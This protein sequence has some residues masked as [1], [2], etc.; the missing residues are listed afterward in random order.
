MSRIL[1][2][3]DD[4]AV[5]SLIKTLLERK[6][7][8]V[9]EAPDGSEGT[10]IFRE[11]PADLVITDIF[12]PEKGGLDTIVELKRDFPEVKIIVISGGGSNM[13]AD[14]CLL[15]SEGL[16]VQQTLHKPLSARELLEG[17]EW[18]LNEETASTFSGRVDGVE[19]LDYFQFMMLSGKKAIVK[20]V[21]AEGRVCMVFVTGGKIVHAVSEEAQGEEAFYDC[22]RFKGGSFFN[23]AWQEPEQVTISKPGTNLL[24]EAARRQDEE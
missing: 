8:E 21:S 6:G 14:G 11:R 16:G 18:V 10:R 15:L 22:A 4:D 2:I 24:I 1:V 23:L 5:R 20:V 12:M 19:I 7:Y 13:T 3:D 9:A 17:V